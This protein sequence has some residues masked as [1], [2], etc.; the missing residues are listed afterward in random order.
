MTSFII[1]GS[2]RRLQTQ[3][4]RDDGFGIT[5]MTK[6]LRTVDDLAN[7][8]LIPQDNAP[9]LREVVERYALSVTPDVAALIEAPDDAIARQFIPDAREL[10][11]APEELTDP[12]GDDAYSPVE[13]IVHRYP[14]RVLLKLLHICPAYCR[15]CFR[16][17]KVGK[18]DKMLGEEGLQ[19]ALNYIAQNKKI[20]EVIFTGGDPLMLS[21]RRIEDVVRRLEPIGH[22]KI[23]R[24]HTRVPMVSPKK[25]TRAL[26]GALQAG[27]KTT[28]IAIHANHPK[29]FTP[30]ARK[31]IALLADAGIPLLSQSVLLKDVNDDAGILEQLMRSFVELRIKPYYLH[32]P[33]LAKGTGHFRFPI[34]R[35]QQ[36]TAELRRRASGLCQ[37][38]YMLDIPG[39]HSKI[40]LAGSY[41]T[42]KKDGYIVRDIWGKAHPY[43]D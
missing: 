3:T 2:P 22:V 19:Q 13:G 7:A 15:F 21:A 11:T 37:P 25:I 40:P 38:S 29:E 36:L 41:L 4:P 24:L 5:I 27:S 34:R 43:H 1:S 26:V 16:R 10:E 12:I 39:G 6:T 17:E 18:E 14:D 9:A 30:A 35:G 20:W 8:N 32:H 42:E 28:Y 23:L 31:S 33:D